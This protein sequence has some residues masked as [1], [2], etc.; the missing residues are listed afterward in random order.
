MRLKAV[1]LCRFFRRTSRAILTGPLV[2]EQV[3][4][5]AAAA[6]ACMTNAMIAADASRGDVGSAYYRSQSPALP[7]TGIEKNVSSSPSSF[8]NSGSGQQQH[9]QTKWEESSRLCDCTHLHSF[10]YDF[11]LRHIDAFLRREYFFLS[12]LVV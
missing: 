2:N 3:C 10:L 6:V 1:E 11:H 8:R 7:Y 5:A 9:G 4:K 12:H